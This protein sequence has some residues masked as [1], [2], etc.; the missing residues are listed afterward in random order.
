MTEQEVIEASI[1][2]C[3]EDFWWFWLAPRW[4]LRIVA[5]K[6]IDKRKLERRFLQWK[7]AVD[8]SDS[9]I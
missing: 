1:D 5:A 2:A 4:Y 7:K 3:R 8:K 6:A 9:C